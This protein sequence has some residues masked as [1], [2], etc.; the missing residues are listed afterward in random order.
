MAKKQP[1]KSPGRPP[2]PPNKKLIR[3]DMWL[4]PEQK[5]IAEQLAEYMPFEQYGTT[6][7]TLRYLVDL[8]IAQL[9]REGILD[10]E[11]FIY[12]DGQ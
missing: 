2:L 9:R 6:A 11:N 7:S 8:G 1:K 12:P 3:T 10:E 5:M 4:R